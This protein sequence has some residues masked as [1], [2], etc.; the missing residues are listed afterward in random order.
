MS[1]DWPAQPTSGSL[2]SRNLDPPAGRGVLRGRDRHAEG[3]GMGKGEEECVVLSGGPTRRRLDP[4]D[5]SSRA[6]RCAAGASP[7]GVE[8]ERVE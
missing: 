1:S 2:P 7:K 6:P 5:I 4:V 8:R 3:Q